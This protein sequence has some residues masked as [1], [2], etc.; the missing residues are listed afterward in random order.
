MKPTKEQ[1]DEFVKAVR[2]FGD[3]SMSAEVIVALADQNAELV[4]LLLRLRRMAADP[5][6]SMDA[7][8]VV[9]AT[10]VDELCEEAL[11]KI[12]ATK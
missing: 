8:Q 7:G 10:R 9:D 12:G 1:I 11:E 6:N 5:M 4:A 3:G 2:E